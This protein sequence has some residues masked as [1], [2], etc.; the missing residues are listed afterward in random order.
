MQIIIFKNSQ[1]KISVTYP[2]NELS[3]EEVLVKDCPAGAVITDS[4]ILPNSFEFMDAWE[5]NNNVITI[6]LEKAKEIK[7]AKINETATSL[8]KQRQLNDLIGVNNG[9]SQEEFLASINSKRTA[10]TNATSI[11]ELNAIVND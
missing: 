9:L 7:I 8:A 2:T 5:F 4:S 3:I 1:N 11:E 10:A 6:N